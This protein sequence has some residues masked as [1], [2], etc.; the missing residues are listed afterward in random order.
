MA[1]YLYSEISKAIQARKTSEERN[2]QDWADKWRDMAEKL[3]RNHLPHGAGF[4]SGTSLDW[5]ASHADKL[6]FRTSYH[7]MNEN[8][9]YDGWTE[10]VVTVT[11]SL[12][13]SFHL[14]VSGRNRNDIKSYVYE[15]F[16]VGLRTD[17]TY[18]IYLDRY[19]EFKITSKWEDKD[20]AQ[21]SCY[22]AWYVNGERF[23]NDWESARKR[24]AELMLQK[25]HSPQAYN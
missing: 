12:Q 5:G 7:H 8:G 1:H 23:W 2:N 9:Y 22:Q 16:D 24:A 25:F 21:S 15:S 19:P 20:G 11:P 17:V 18:D 6:V 13:H 14:R 3:V 10:H 4:D